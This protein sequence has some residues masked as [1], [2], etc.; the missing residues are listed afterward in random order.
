MKNHLF[1]QSNNNL[2]QTN[3][4]D[5]SINP[6]KLRKTTLKIRHDIER[7]H[8]DL[9]NEYPPEQYMNLLH[10]R[11]EMASYTYTP[12]ELRRFCHNIIRQS[13]QRVLQWYHKLI[14]VSFIDKNRTTLHHINMPGSIKELY[15]KSFERI[16][17]EIEINP[18]EFYEYPQ[19]K[20]VKD[21][22]ICALKLIPMGPCVIELSEIPA[23]FLLKKGLSQFIKGVLFVSF[24]LGGFKPFYQIHTYRSGLAEFNEHE[25]DRAYLRIADLLKIEGRVKGAFGSSWFVD[26]R[27][28]LIS[29]R[30]AYLKERFEQNGGEIFYLESTMEDVRNATL[31]SPTRRRLYKE[32]KYIPRKYMR[33]WP[34][35]QLISWAERYHTNNPEAM[36]VLASH[37]KKAMMQ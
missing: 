19:D 7:R 10:N 9:L 35:K 1:D 20:F 3:N 37:R 16:V 18:D 13:D 28:K 36:D 21:L 17:R 12:P 8:K 5:I 14:I 23:S 32:G 6:E 30:L 11:P 4:R 29:P 27:I 2:M 22:N 33:I 25:W 31:K 26:P 34:R 15:V 24:Q